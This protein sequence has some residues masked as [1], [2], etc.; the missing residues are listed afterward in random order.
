V[1]DVWVDEIH[2]IR[3]GKRQQ[4]PRSSPHQEKSSP[5]DRGPDPLQVLL[6]SFTEVTLRSPGTVQ[7]GKGAMSPLGMAIPSWRF[8]WNRPSAVR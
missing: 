6:P 7:E 3:C 4:H 8:G 2:K 5:G 1:G